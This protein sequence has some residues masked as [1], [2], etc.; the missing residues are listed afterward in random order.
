MLLERISVGPSVLIAV[1]VSLVHVS[2]AALLWMVPFPVI[3][4]AVVTLAIA[5]SLVYFMARDA[6]LHAKASIVALEVREDGEIACQTRS[7]EWIECELLPSTYVTPRVTVINLRPHRGWL[8]RRVILVR[9]NVDA[10]DF[11]RLRMWLR[12]KRGIASPGMPAPS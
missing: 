1:G 10:R 9:D 6:A 8:S 11:R 12:W 7:G 5:L 3:V 2:A 4:K